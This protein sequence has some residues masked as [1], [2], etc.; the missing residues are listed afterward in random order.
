MS[1][2]STTITPAPIPSNPVADIPDPQDLL[3][4]QA[5]VEGAKPPSFSDFTSLLSK[6]K[7]QDAPKPA[8]TPKDENQPTPKAKEETPKGKETETPAPAPK[9]NV[10]PPPPKKESKKSF[11]GIDEADLPIFKD[12]AERMSDR[13]WEVTAKLYRENK[14]LKTKAAIPP[15]TPKEGELP[16]NY[17]SNPN[18]YMLSPEYGQLASMASLADRIHNHWQEQFVRINQDEPWVDIKGIDD[19]GNLVYAEPQAITTGTKPA[20]VAKMISNIRFSANNLDKYQGQRDAYSVEFK[21]KHEAAIG[22]VRQMSDTFF[23]DWDKPDHPTQAMQKE[24]LKQLGE[25]WSDNPLAG[26]VTKGRVFVALQQAKIKELEE[27][28][29]KLKGV[30]KLDEVVQPK[31]ADIIPGA[32][33][34]PERPTF[35]DYQK[36][37]NKAA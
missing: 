27:E 37:L 1:E 13:A 18:A 6:G 22:Q 10:T 4:T 3:A 2:S 23:K 5:P 9:P 8:E 29:A 35:A 15:P 28:L 17:Y 33:V 26:F 19:A 20:L 34:K 14:E 25:Y 21:K 30:K 36:I 24:L 31:K 12:I 32:S 11:E 7:Q 16:S